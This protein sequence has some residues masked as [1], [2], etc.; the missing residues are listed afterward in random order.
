[1]GNGAASTASFSKSAVI[2]STSFVS[3]TA[4]RISL[5]RVTCNQPRTASVRLV[6]RLTPQECCMTIAAGV[7]SVQFVVPVQLH[8][9][10]IKKSVLEADTTVRLVAMVCKNQTKGTPT[11]P[12]ARTHVRN[13]RP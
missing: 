3:A 9:G 13:N 10:H 4:P 1:M 2:R 12:Q 11:A 8:P 5:N 7:T 6:D